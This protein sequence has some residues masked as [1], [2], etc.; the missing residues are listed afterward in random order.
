[1]PTARSLVLMAC[2]GLVV[3]GVGSGCGKRGSPETAPTAGADVEPGSRPAIPVVG[4]PVPRPS[5][6]AGWVEYTHPEGVFTVHTPGRPRLKD[7]SRPGTLRNPPPGVSPWTIHAVDGKELYVEME[8]NVVP[9]DQA[10][11]LRADLKR[12]SDETRRNNPGDKFVDRNVTWAGR[13]AEETEHY[14]DV[15][16]PASKSGTARRLRVGRDL[17]V[18]GTAYS[19]RIEGT[20]AN[21]PTAGERAAFFDSF[22]LGK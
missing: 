16:D 13:P 17:W 20:E 4:A 3:V 6:P 15:R 14:Y 9:F 21:R 18:G 11:Q 8:V 10:A 1:M 19:F 7:R 22:V 12:Q 2:A 5:L